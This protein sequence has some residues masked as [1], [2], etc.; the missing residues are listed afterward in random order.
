MPR[1]RGDNIITLLFELPWQIAA[2]LGAITYLVAPY[3]AVRLVGH[4]QS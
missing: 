4:R 1:R 2:V 3:I